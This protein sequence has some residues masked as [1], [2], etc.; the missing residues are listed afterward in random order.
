MVGKEIAANFSTKGFDRRTLLDTLPSDALKAKAEGIA[1]KQIEKIEAKIAREQAKAK[2]A[3]AK[4]IDPG[5]DGTEQ[6]EHGTVRV[7]K[8]EYAA[9][10][11]T[12][13]G[14]VEYFV[15]DETKAASKTATKS[16]TA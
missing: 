6:V 15:G 9:V 16:F 7:G 3:E 12:A 11:Y 4:S 14:K 13:T 10:R 2:K 8:N 1:E 5:D